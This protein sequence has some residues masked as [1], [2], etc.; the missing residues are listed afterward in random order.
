MKYIRTEI[1]INAPVSTVWDTLMDFKNYPTWNPFIH[2]TGKAQAGQQLE[3]TIFLEGQKPQ[4][5]KP[6][7]LE[8]IPQK[9]LRWEGHL[10]IKGLFDGEH[11]FQL[12]AIGQQQTK[13]IHG[14]NFR[15]IL[16]TLVLKMVD[17]AT[18][19]GFNKMNKAL[20]EQCEV[21]VIQI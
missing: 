16:S 10:F 11:Y 18:E 9:I 17:S 3:N 2:I 5:F 21:A 15:G 12:E 7:V 19:D 6:T 4:V 1:I 8:V 14:E 13:L 20:K